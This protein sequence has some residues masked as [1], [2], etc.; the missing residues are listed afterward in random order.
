LERFSLLKEEFHMIRMP[1][2]GQNFSMKFAG[3]GVKIH[4][5]NAASRTYIER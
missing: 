5:L 1:I 2:P 3:V 4:R